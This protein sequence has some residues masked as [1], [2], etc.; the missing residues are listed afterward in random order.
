MEAGEQGLL[1]SLGPVFSVAI[2]VHEEYHGIR[3]WA[4]LE[5]H[6][7]ASASFGESEVIKL[8]WV[9]DVNLTPLPKAEECEI[10]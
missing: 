4:I 5:E 6:K 3:T 10:N 9:L 1:P 7:K 8:A 2:R